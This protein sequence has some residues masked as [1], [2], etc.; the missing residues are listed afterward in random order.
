M[1]N[2]LVINL[3][4]K[5]FSIPSQLVF[6][7]PKTLL[8]NQEL[9]SKY[10]RTDRNDY[11]FERNSLLFPYIFTYYTL[12]KKIFC[13]RH[14]PLELIRK[15]CEFFQLSYSKIYRELNRL[16]TYEYFPRNL[17]QTSDFFLEIVPFI[18]GLAFLLTTSM[19]RLDNLSSYSSWS[20]IYFTELFSTLFLSST[21]VYQMIFLEEVFQRKSFFIDI[22]SVVMSIASITLQ[23]V[24][25]ITTQHWMY[26]FMLICKIFRLSIVIVH[27]QILRLIGQTFIQKFETISILVF[28][29]LILISSFSEIAFAFERR[30]VEDQTNHATM[31]THFD[32]FWWATS[33]SFSI[34]FGYTDAHSTLTTIGRF[35]SYMLTFFGLLFNGLIL[36]ELIKGFLKL[37]RDDRRD[38]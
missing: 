31:K 26:M 30:Q 9:L 1:E 20:F 35:C 28:L 11:Y 8:G 6:R 10:Y 29:N 21:V 22:F 13:P 24:I 34:G 18:S 32:A 25:T 3:L 5:R 38:Q 12:D 15:E 37:Y 27:L 36:Q 2:T 17:R 16:E 14:I 7:Y 23:T 19:E 4:G 33:L